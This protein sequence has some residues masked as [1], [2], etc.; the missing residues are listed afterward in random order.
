MSQDKRK[1]LIG[2]VVSDKMNKTV[3]VVIVRRV[4]HPLVKKYINRT[5]KILAH[6]ENNMAKVGDTVKIKEVRPISKRKRWLVVEI[7][8]KAGEQIQTILDNGS[9]TYDTGADKT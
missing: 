1:T 6:N 9:E 5:T 3:K 8:K 2:E 7:I 4:K